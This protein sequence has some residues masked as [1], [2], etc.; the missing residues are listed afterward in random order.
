MTSKAQS[1]VIIKGQKYLI[2]K[3]SGTV[4]DSNGKKMYKY[5]VKKDSKGYEYLL[6]KISDTIVIQPGKYTKIA[7]SE[8]YL[9]TKNGDFEGACELNGDIIIEANQYGTVKLDSNH[10]GFKVYFSKYSEGN[11]GYIDI[12]G[13]CIFPVSI[14]TAIH[15]QKN[16][17]FVIEAYGKAGIADSLGNIKYMTKYRSLDYRTDENGM[18]YYVTYLGNGRGKMELDGNII[19]EPHPTIIKEEKIEDGFSWVRI[20]GTNGLYGVISNAG[21]QIIPCNYDLIMYDKRG[22]GFRIKKNGRWGF[23]DADGNI[24]VHA[25]NYDDITTLYVKT[26][27]TVTKANKKGVLDNKGKIIIEPNW[28]YISQLND[29]LFLVRN[30]N[31]EGVID[32][33]SNIIIPVEYTKVSL[34]DN[35]FNVSLNGKKGIC[36]IKG[37]VIVPA[38]YTSVFPTSMGSYLNKKYYAVKDGNTQG[39]YSFDGKLIF[40]TGLFKEV[41][42]R[43][44][45]GFEEK[46]QDSIYV[47]AW[48]DDDGQTCYY[49]LDGNLIY[50]DRL[51]NEFDKIFKIAGQ[52]FKNKNYSQAISYYEQALK[53]KNDGTAYYNIGA[54]Y[55][56]INKYK[57]AIK[58]LEKCLIYS[59]SQREKDLALD[60]Q[61][62][63]KQAIQEKRQ[64]NA[65]IW[66]GV[67]GCAL[68]VGAS[69]LQSNQ[70]IS[71]SRFMLAETN[72]Y[73]TSLGVSA[74]PMPDYDLIYKRAMVEINAQMEQQKEEFISQYRRNFNAISGRMPTESEEYGAYVQY[75]KSLN[76][77]NSA[78]NNI[79]STS[80]SSPSQSSSSTNSSSINSSGKKCVKLH[81][82]DHAHCN[83]EKVCSKCNGKKAYWDNG[84]GIEHYVDPCVVCNGSG[85]CPGCAGTGVR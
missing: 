17:T 69:I 21:K 18:P 76:E 72:R 24:I 2:D 64:R 34:S 37:N 27:F 43:K 63:C 23:A 74:P 9:Y 25:E 71:D 85:L 73:Y 62:R 80:S 20:L 79:S 39:A 14:Y 30:N 22:Q 7:L 78:S 83:G 68:D 35:R 67:L 10:N 45:L 12:N 15:S 75:L 46:V 28:N 11:V 13:K 36:D 32:K 31:Y 51:D 50:D 40:P 49:D 70:R 56:N 16:G 29:S 52:E 44:N 66:L 3:S 59:Q 77:I 65:A 48:N 55:Y 5:E 60:L 33:N 4:S 6:N 8:G 26:G 61:I 41:H 1:P 84:Y 42:I 81:A 57:D 47:C 82:S 38:A 58:A 19:E 54:A 53:K